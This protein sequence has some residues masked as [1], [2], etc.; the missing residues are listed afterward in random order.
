[1]RLSSSRR[2]QSTS[3]ASSSVV[4]FLAFFADDG[5]DTATT[6]GSSSCFSDVGGPS[7]AANASR[8]VFS[9]VLAGASAVVC[10]LGG[11]SMARG[12][13]RVSG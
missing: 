9:V 11:S 3:Y 5:R 12:S 13:V 10:F 2:M 7:M 6:P 1:M 4:G 8:S